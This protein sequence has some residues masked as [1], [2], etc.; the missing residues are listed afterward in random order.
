MKDSRK[1]NSKPRNSKIIKGPD[2]V[3]Y[4][5]FQFNKDGYSIRLQVC[6]TGRSWERLS[7]STL[8]RIL[9]DARRGRTI[10]LIYNYSMAVVVIQG[11]NLNPVVDAIA[12]NKCDSVQAFDPERWDLPT[13]QDAPFIES[14]TINVNPVDVHGKPA[15]KIIDF[16]SVKNGTPSELNPA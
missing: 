8:F 15:E 9:E 1:K 13:D 2:K 4:A 12:M 10:A 3:P 11:R 5:A 6:P 7:Y 16:Y 14:I